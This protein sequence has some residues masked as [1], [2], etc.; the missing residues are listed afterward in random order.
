MI[1][2]WKETIL[3]D[4][5][6]DVSC[7]YTESAKQEKAG[8][9]FLRITDN[10]NGRVDWNKVPYC[11]ITEDNFKKYQLLPGILSLPELEQQQVVITPSKIKPE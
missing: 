7:G 3:A 4:L 6:T 2:E 9:K 5:C 8:P 1:S 10:A 11:P